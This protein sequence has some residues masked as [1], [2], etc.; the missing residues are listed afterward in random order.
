MMATN[1]RIVS[2]ATAKATGSV[3]MATGP[4]NT[5]QSTTNAASKTPP[6]P[7]RPHVSL[8]RGRTAALTVIIF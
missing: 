8:V 4:I 6:D 3:P 7:T 1:G 5:P 2:A